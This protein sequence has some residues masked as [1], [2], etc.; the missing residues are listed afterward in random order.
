MSSPQSDAEPVSLARLVFQGGSYDGMALSGLPHSF[1]VLK[2]A[3][4]SRFVG[5]WNKG[6]FVL[7]QSTRPGDLKCTGQVLPQRFCSLCHLHHF[8]PAL[9]Y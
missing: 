1:G 4:G 3:D 7:G 8:T 5:E 2:N 6:V 9:S